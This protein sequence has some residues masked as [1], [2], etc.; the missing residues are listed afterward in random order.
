MNGEHHL[1]DHIVAMN[2]EE[3]DNNNVV[4]DASS[5]ILADP[6]EV[7]ERGMN[8]RV[9]ATAKHN[10]V[11]G[12]QVFYYNR[13]TQDLFLEALGHPSITVPKDCTTPT[14][15]AKY[16]ADTYE[17]EM[18]L[19]EMV[20]ATI[21]NGEWVIVWRDK[22][23]VWRGEYRFQ[24]EQERDLEVLLPVTTFEGLNYPDRPA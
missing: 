5:L 14:L 22:S 23:Y 4:L 24:H 20:S 12:E 11:E 15:M 10:K 16:F 6:Y 17:V 13:L 1:I 2:K 7:F 19:A 8:T 18:D 9:V 21:V 3:I